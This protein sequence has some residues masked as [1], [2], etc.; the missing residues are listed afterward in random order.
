MSN[1]KGYYDM[2]EDVTKTNTVTPVNQPYTAAKITEGVPKT[3][4]RKAQLLLEK[5]KKNDAMNWNDKGELKIGEDV[6]K[7]S[8]IT[9]LINDVLHARKG[10]DPLGW[11]QFV[12]GLAS[13]NVPETL[14]GNVS[15]RTIVQRHKQNLM[16][17]NEKR[18]LPVLPTATSKANRKRVTRAYS[19]HRPKKQLLWESL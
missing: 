5:I 1:P 14:V 12:R 11:Q 7:G 13:M 2:T 16:T 17:P 15:R 3:Y 10:F 18:V 6:V 4:K 9:D 19:R 8:N